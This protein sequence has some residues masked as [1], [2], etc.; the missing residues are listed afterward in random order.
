RKDAG[1]EPARQAR[2]GRATADARAVAV[3]A[4]SLATGEDAGVVLEGAD[5]Q[6]RAALK[7][8][9]AVDL[10]AGDQEIHAT[11]H[12][13]EERLAHAEGQL[14]NIAEHKSLGHVP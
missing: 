12:R 9:D 10:P 11:R 7:S 4:G 8:R 3:V 5:D 6:R 2:I 1:V 13:R 14:V